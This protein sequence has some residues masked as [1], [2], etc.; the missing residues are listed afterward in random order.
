LTVND[1]W[2]E[3][4]PGDQIVIQGATANF[5]VVAHGSP[6]LSFA[7]YRE[8]DPVNPLT[9]TGKYS[10]ADTDHLVVT[11]VQASEIDSYYC[12]VTNAEGTD[13]SRHALLSTNDPG[14]TTQPTSQTADP[15][16]P[17]SFTC[18]GVTAHPPIKYQWY[19]DTTLLTGSTTSTHTIASCA[20]DANN[21]AIF[22]CRVANSEVPAKTIDSNTATLTVNGEP[23]AWSWVS[24]A[25]INKKLYVGQLANWAVSASGGFP[26]SNALKYQWYLGATP[27][28]DATTN[29][30]TV[31][32]VELTDAGAYSCQISDDAPASFWKT[33]AGATLEVGTTLRIVVPYPE[34]AD[35]FVGDSHTFTVHTEGGV[36]TLSYQWKQDGGILSGRTLSTLA[37][38]NLKLSDI[39]DYTVTVTDENTGA[40]TSE[41]ATLNVS[42]LPNLLPVAGLAGLALLVGAF[43]AGAAVTARRKRS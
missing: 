43:A 40:A 3:P 32:P 10:G 15:G 6:T 20:Y 25:T 39:G 34:G 37:L 27:I 42:E 7:W 21:G 9:N 5:V 16:A 1:P 35:L 41:P 2:I 19:R 26:N 12:V 24:P 11:N 22:W 23:I 36:G 13:E 18:V 33:A 8:D 31:Y 17:A 4:G 14:I 30:L 28:T 38:T 29:A